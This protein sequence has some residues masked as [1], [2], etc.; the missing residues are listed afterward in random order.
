VYHQSAK[1]TKIVPLGAA[2]CREYFTGN[3]LYFQEISPS[4]CRRCGTNIIAW[5]WF[6]ETSG[7][8]SIFPLIKQKGRN[9]QKRKD[10]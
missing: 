6:M 1:V 7:N 4:E 2:A 9:F 10:G 8:C 3:H 5:R